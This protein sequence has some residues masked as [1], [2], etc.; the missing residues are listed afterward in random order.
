MNNFDTE[1]NTVQLPLCHHDTEWAP[2]LFPST[3]IP[4]F[5]KRLY[6]LNLYFRF[7]LIT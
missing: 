2:H 7:V 5:R 6:E 3:A 4:L 1:K